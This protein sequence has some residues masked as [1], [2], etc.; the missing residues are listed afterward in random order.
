M[1]LVLVLVLAS[2]SQT[3]RPV[4]APRPDCPLVPRHV[5]PIVITLDGGGRVKLEEGIGYIEERGQWRQLAD[6]YSPDWFERAYDVG[7]DCAISR[8]DDRGATW[9]V[10]RTLDDGFDGV[11][12]FL[13]LFG[14]D[15][16]WTAMTLQSPS[17][18]EVKDYVA[19]RQCLIER[20]CSY[21]DNRF[22]VRDEPGR[23]A[24]VR[25]TSVP[26][27][28]GMITAKASFE[29]TLGYF[30]KGD[31]VWFR[32]DVRVVQGVPFGLFDLESTYLDSAPGP[33]VI[34]VGSPPALAVELKFLD[35]PMYTQSAGAAVP[36][37][38]GRWVRLEAHLVLDDGP[39]GTVEL[40]QDG[41]K[42]LSA[43]GRTLPISD[44]VLDSVELGITATNDP[45]DTVVDLDAVRISTTPP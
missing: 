23:G 40:W 18:P 32:A 11:T 8:R 43:T 38:L 1:R 34:L 3:P 16:G 35:K 27:S 31:D 25:A 24:Y 20:T 13:D 21:R 22:D 30:V 7:A 6:V 19:L 9:P 17:A 33:R 28:P 41:A 15:R 10:R 36:F 4:A 14:P 44:L 29:S 45:G 12:D 2:C 39:S 5:D 26:K 37:P 42:V